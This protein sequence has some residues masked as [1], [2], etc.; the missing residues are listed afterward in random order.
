MSDT[1]RNFLLTEYENGSRQSMKRI[2]TLRK[3]EQRESKIAEA[4][5]MAAGN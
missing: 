5:G 1:L 4:N 2:L 3:S